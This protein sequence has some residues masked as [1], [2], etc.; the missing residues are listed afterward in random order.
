MSEP[1]V[2]Q[3]VGGG[4]ARLTINQPAKGNTLTPDV[5]DLLERALGAVEGDESVVVV[6][7]TGAGERQF[8]GGLHSDLVTGEN[9]ARAPE[10][11]ER[12]WRLAKR[13]AD[14]RPVVIGSINGAAY[15]GGFALAM[16]CD[17]RVASDNAT[18]TYPGTE[19]GLAVGT[20][21]LP[22]LIGPTWAKEVLLLAKMVTAADAY[23]MGMINQ[24]VPPAE[25]P[26]A[27]QALVDRC[28][29]LSPQGLR[30]TKL[31][32][33]RALRSHPDEAFERE[34]EWLA[35][36]ASGDHVQHNFE[37]AIAARRQRRAQRSGQSS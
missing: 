10:V 31:L 18:F 1:V 37:R 35:R 27:T 4:L 34:I 36:F 14:L 16:A 23:R 2:L 25:L 21:Q 26:A 12:A 6:V 17:L 24:V 22:Y 5:Q 19:Y 30:N 28:L 13:V 29:A 3:E 20:F 33:N 9:R 7:I 15:A 8:C 32:I 11:L